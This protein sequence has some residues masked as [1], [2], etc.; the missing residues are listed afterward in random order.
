MNPLA[1][2]IAWAVVGALAGW[3]MRW[4]SVKLAR[5]EGLEP[6][7]KRWQVYGPP[8]VSA[9]LFAV[10]GYALAG[11]PS[12]LALQIPSVIRSLTIR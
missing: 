7:F 9:D 5:L 4:G 3:V 8:I 1:V 10:F 11:S 2:A 6:G 12:L